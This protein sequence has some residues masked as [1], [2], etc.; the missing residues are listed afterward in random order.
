MVRNPN[1]SR[2]LGRDI[3]EMVLVA[4]LFFPLFGGRQHMFIVSYVGKNGAKIRKPRLCTIS[5]HP[6]VIILSISLETVSGCHKFFLIKMPS[7]DTSQ[8][9]PCNLH[10]LSIEVLTF[11]YSLWYKSSREEG[12]N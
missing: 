12:R 8:L 9:H 6:W 4:I 2:Y 3:M 7:M 5:L 10:H 1:E 11:M